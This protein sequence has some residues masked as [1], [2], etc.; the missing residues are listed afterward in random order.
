MHTSSLGEEDFDSRQEISLRMVPQWKLVTDLPHQLH[1]T[2]I[3]H[4][5]ILIVVLGG[6]PR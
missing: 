4:L 3:H 2:K 6:W 5:V 1:L